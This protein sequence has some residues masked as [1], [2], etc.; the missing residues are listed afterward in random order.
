M[1]PKFRLPLSPNRTY[2]QNEMGPPIKRSPMIDDRV[3]L[4]LSGVKP[5]Q[6]ISDS[7]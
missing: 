5:F 7:R 1:I 3:I 6:D 4:L 2:L